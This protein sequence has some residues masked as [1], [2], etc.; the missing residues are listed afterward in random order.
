ATAVSLFGLAFQLVFA[1]ALL[2]Y[3][4]FGNDPSAF[5]GSLATF[6][7]V[8]IWL[9][10][11][12]VFHQHR[13]ERL[14]AIEIEAFRTSAAAES[15]VFE[16]TGAGEDVQA[17]KLAWMHKWFL[18]ATSLVIGAG[19]VTLGFVMFFRNQGYASHETFRTPELTGWA[20]AIGVATAAIGFVFARFVAGMA[21]QPV[22]RLLNAGAGAAVGTALLGAALFTGHFLAQAL[23]S[24]GLLRYLP[25]VIDI[26]MI[27]L[28]VEVG[29]NFVL[30][31][32][33]PRRPGEYLR[34]AMDSRILAFLAAP[35]RLAE[36][37]SEAVN[38]QFGFDVSSTWFYRLISRSIALLVIL[39]VLTI[40]MMTAFTVV[41]PDERGLV[42]RG[43]KFERQVES[44]LVIK[45]PWPFDRVVTFPAQS[46]NE[47][48]V[49]SATLT[50]GND[51]GPILWTAERTGS[52]RFLIVRPAASTQGDSRGVALVSVEIPIHYVVEDLFAY[53][54]LAQDGP[55]SDRDAIRKDLLRALSSRVVLEYLSNYTVDEILGADR[56]AI[57][58]RLGTLLQEQYDAI[59]AGVRLVFVGLQGV[60]PPQ[61]VASSFEQV[62]AADQKRSAEIE[63]AET[64]RIRQLAAAAGDIDRAQRIVE[65]IGQL[66]ELGGPG[67]E[68]QDAAELELLITELIEQAGG[69]A[70]IDIANAR[71]QRWERH[72]GER[73][74]AVRAMGQR[75]MYAAAP[76]AF[77]AGVYLEAMRSLMSGVRVWIVPDDELQLRGNF[78]ETQVDM[79]GYDGSGLETDNEEN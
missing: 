47:V 29:L 53:T 42:L 10:L 67:A 74:R 23:G 26:Y 20:I 45:R 55:S 8:P 6:L 13:L 12:L 30:T 32:Y 72:M 62:V 48:T 44:G 75:A 51:R 52:E 69:Q 39:G 34:P 4:I 19:Y 22:W 60:T 54:K 46:I 1:L 40:W 28:G 15:S 78:E 68:G 38:Y 36:S 63:R 76:E 25:M 58:Q 24:D 14:E 16:E 57:G 43:G 3:S 65:A 66:N 61:D 9:S 37:I 5:S 35:D 18:P 31:L 73:V 49:G 79:I 17:R 21:K 77:L 11:A 56:V 2:I 27:A 59:E 33:R 41:Q 64:Y 71:R 70:A 50:T 7:G